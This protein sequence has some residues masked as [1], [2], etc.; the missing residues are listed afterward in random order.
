M[1]FKEKK[2]IKEN[3]NEIEN[4]KSLINE[5]LEKI[6]DVVIYNNYSF[7][8][9]DI[10]NNVAIDKYSMSSIFDFS[11]PLYK[12]SKNYIENN[13][14]F[15]EK[16]QKDKIL[17][18]IGNDF[19]DMF[20]NINITINLY[21][22]N[23]LSFDDSDMELDLYNMDIKEISDYIENNQYGYDV[24]DYICYLETIYNFYESLNKSIENMINKYGEYIL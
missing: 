14:E 15:I 21:I 22:V 13:T 18:Y 7:I 3:K 23:E 16:L 20:K 5:N 4:M 9:D 12:E 11:E 24:L 19:K 1:D 6:N 10:R 8:I 17:H 2:E